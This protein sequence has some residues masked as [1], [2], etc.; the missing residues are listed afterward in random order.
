M[1]LS[2]KTGQFETSWPQFESRSGKIVKSA[3]RER[4][5]ER[6]IEIQIERQ[7]ERQRN[8]KFEFSRLGFFHFSSFDWKTS[9]RKT[10]LL[11]DCFLF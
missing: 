9:F 2:G 11:S 1:W 6:Q 10:F 4:Q 7:R 8:Q 5:I 3:K